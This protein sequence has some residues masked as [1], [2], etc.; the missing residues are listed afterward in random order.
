MNLNKLCI[1]PRARTPWEAIDLGC[2][3]AMQWFKP[4]FLLYAIPFYCVALVS[5]LVSYL[6]S[7]Y[8]IFIGLF[9][10]WLLKPIYERAPLFFASRALFN[11]KPSVKTVFSNFLKINRLNF[12]QWLTLRRLSPTRSF[13]MPVTVLEGLSGSV[14]SKR[15]GIIHVRGSGEAL[16]LTFI[17]NTIEMLLV[18]GAYALLLLIVPEPYNGQMLDLISESVGGYSVLYGLIYVILAPLIGPFYICAGFILYINRRVQLEAWDIDIQF[19]KIAGKEKYRTLFNSISLLT[20][21]ALLGLTLFSSQPSLAQT[22]EETPTETTDITEETTDLTNVELD[23][24]QR[25][26]LAEESKQQIL[27]ITEGS[28]F[29]RTKEVTKWR[30]K[31]QDNV[32][33]ESLFSKLGNAIRDFFERLL[34]DGID[35]KPIDKP[36]IDL[37]SLILKFT[38]IALLVAAIAY[39]INRYKSNF[40]FLNKRFKR[41][42]RAI[43]HKPVPETLFGLSVTKHDLPQNVPDEVIHI[44]DTEGPRKAVSLLYRACLSHLI[45]EKGFQ[46]RESQT[47]EECLNIVRKSGNSLDT[48]Y[49]RDVTHLWQ[50]LAYGHTQPARKKVEDLCLNWQKVFSNDIQN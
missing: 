40:A 39:L 48:N 27:D 34:G 28:D 2:K 20:C 43:N 13:D 22:V 25:S 7:E 23:E 42:N 11:D 3:L 10:T 4:L 19:Q 1:N 47:E 26:A 9:I 37:A 5:I 16:A 6:F 24:K 44:F 33:D 15:I 12:F 41:S 49:L 8:F 18:I 50:S 45:H 29:N 30:L 36:S 35:A 32:D 46:F 21:T 14:R 17:C 31:T 38:L